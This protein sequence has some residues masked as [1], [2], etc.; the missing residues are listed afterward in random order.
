MYWNALGINLVILM[1]IVLACR[2][3]HPLPLEKGGVYTV[4][5]KPSPSPLVAEN[6]NGT[7]HLL[8]LES[9]APVNRPQSAQM[10]VKRSALR[11]PQIQPAKR[12]KIMPPLTPDSTTAF[13][14]PSNQPQ[15]QSK[16]GLRSRMISMDALCGDQRGRAVKRSHV[17]FLQKG[18]SVNSYVEAGLFARESGWMLEGSR[19]ISRM[20]IVSNPFPW[21]IWMQMAIK[22][23]ILS[24]RKCEE[25]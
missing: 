17:D 7:V 4:T 12:R 11:E 6:Q 23:Q 20:C 3:F 13:A 21:E 19:H 15:P 1:R 8:S 9:T 5:R 10:G 2:A 16:D 25:E 22:V 14:K 24:K 18:E